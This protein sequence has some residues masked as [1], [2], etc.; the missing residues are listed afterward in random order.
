[1]AS[2]DDVELPHLA[3]ISGNETLL[4]SAGLHD[5]T[6][7]FDAIA[8]RQEQMSRDATTEIFGFMRGIVQQLGGLAVAESIATCILDGE[9]DER[10]GTGTT[11]ELLNRI[12]PPSHWR[13]MQQ[14]QQRVEATAARRT[15][16]TT[17]A[18]RA[19]E[20]GG[21]RFLDLPRGQRRG[22]WEAKGSRLFWL[23]AARNRE[24]PELTGMQGER[25]RG[26]AKMSWGGNEGTGGGLFFQMQ[27]Y[28]HGQTTAP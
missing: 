3:Y 14:P 28:G 24:C 15:L 27:H 6:V 18:S 7:A 8:K 17:L 16:L 19:M 12:S 1:M 20:T 22:E 11:A 23:G 10:E 4:G 13:L 26:R 25:L 9:L 5:L 2:H 21:A